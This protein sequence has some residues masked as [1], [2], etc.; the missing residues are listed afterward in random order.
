MMRSIIE[1]TISTAVT[2]SL[3]AG[4]CQA[5]QESAVWRE[6]NL[7]FGEAKMTSSGEC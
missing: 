4:L 1:F 6:F 7:A 3:L 5:K 2:F